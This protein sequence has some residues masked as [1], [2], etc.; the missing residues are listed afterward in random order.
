MRSGL[1]IWIFASNSFVLPMLRIP[2]GDLSVF[3]S[4]KP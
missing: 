2:S 1:T 4:T 3:D